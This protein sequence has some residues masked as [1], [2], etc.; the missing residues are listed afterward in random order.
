DLTLAG[1]GDAA[2][3]GATAVRTAA[4][5]TA[6]LAGPDGAALLA[7]AELTGDAATPGEFIGSSRFPGLL[8]G[9]ANRPGEFNRQFFAN[10]LTGRELA[11]E[12]QPS[13]RW[14]G[15]QARRA[16]GAGDYVFDFSS[17]PFGTARPFRIDFANPAATA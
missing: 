11:P 8:I 9:I 3:N 13:V 2:V 16:E 6:V 15:A 10:V 5:L 7:T 1:F 4:A 17:D 12:G 14:D